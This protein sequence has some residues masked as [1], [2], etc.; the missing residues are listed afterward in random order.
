[1]IDRAKQEYVSPFYI[2]LCCFP[3]GE[4]DLGFEWLD[5]AYKERD[6]WLLYL[7]VEPLFDSVRSDPRFTKLVKKIGLE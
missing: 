1:M 3:L 4:N 5:K 6:H 2:A 7:N